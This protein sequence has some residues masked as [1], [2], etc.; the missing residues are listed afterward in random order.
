MNESFLINLSK[1]IQEHI[2]TVKRLR[3]VRE[4]ITQLV[5]Y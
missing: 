5:V 4:M 3:L 2:K 1:T